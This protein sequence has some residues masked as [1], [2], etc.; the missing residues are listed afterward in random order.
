[1]TARLSRRAAL[2]AGLP[3]LATPAIAQSGRTL[4]MVTSWPRGL[5]GLATS[6][7]RFAET[8]TKLSDGALTI[9]V[10]PGGQLVGPFAVHD[11]V[12][13][14]EAEFYHSAEYYFQG[15][16]RGMNFF[17]TVPLGFTTA[18]QD[19]WISRGGGQALWD[20]LNAEF[21]VKALNCGGTGVQMG[22]WFAKRI[23]TIDDLRATVMRIPGLGGQVLRELDVETVV[24][25]AAGIVEAL[26]SGEIG[27][28]E[29]VGPWNDLNFGF[30]KLLT[31]YIYPGFH[32]P[33]TMAAVGMNLDFWRGLSPSERQIIETAAQR[34]MLLHT[35]EYYHFNGFAL[36]LLLEEYG[37]EPTRL[38][39]PVFATIAEKS[40]EV[41]ASV[42]EDDDL[43]RRI[44]ESFD[45]FRSQIMASVP[46]SAKGAF[47]TNRISGADVL[48]AVRHP[49]P[50][51]L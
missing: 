23:E 13:A 29:W 10:F 49:L 51:Q 42:A 34:E 32:E 16:H 9:E 11:A 37:V 45:A 25:P 30:Q 4:R 31:T 48:P 38:P 21:N 14:G 15:K 40:R 2:A 8:V 12:G 46:L 36:R 6:A 35:S 18:E 39:A 22:G 47:L 33:G 44:Y 1:M 27:A 17:T 28:T 7:D 5:D 24:L 26:F 3:A 20:E 43:G 19:A 41:V 50:M